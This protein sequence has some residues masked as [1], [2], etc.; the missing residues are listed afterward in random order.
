ML[1]S[2]NDLKI[3]VSLTVCFFKIGLLCLLAIH[4]V[5]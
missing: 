5:N 2:D 3:Y 4:T 1:L